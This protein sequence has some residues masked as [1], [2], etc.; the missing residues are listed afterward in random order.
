MAYNLFLLRV[1]DG[2][3]PLPSPL[4]CM[5]VFDSICTDPLSRG[6]D[7]TAVARDIGAAVMERVRAKQ[8]REES[9][10]IVGMQ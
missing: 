3:A 8:R 1:K 5:R 7:D 9:V 2:L 10:L 4:L 6:I